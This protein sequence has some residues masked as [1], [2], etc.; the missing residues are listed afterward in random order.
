MEERGKRSQFERLSYGKPVILFNEVEGS[1]CPIQEAKGSLSILG[2]PKPA[3]PLKP[4]LLESGENF[5]LPTNPFELAKGSLS[6]RVL[7]TRFRSETGLDPKDAIIVSR[8]PSWK[9]RR[10]KYEIKSPQ[11]IQ[12]ERND[13]ANK[14]T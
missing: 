11:Q 13:I 6:R 12:K 5:Y 7:E 2:L 3:D 10:D 14:I 8:I 1:F 9:V 4:I